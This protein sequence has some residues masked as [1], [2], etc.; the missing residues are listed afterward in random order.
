[1]FSFQT[2]VFEI[3]S[4]IEEEFGEAKTH[5]IQC[6]EPMA[7]LSE[8]FRQVSDLFFQCKQ[9]MSRL[10]NLIKKYADEAGEFMNVPATGEDGHSENAGRMT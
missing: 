9:P 4:E 3:V 6:M 8:Q 7:H 1:M 10:N 2:A 5:F